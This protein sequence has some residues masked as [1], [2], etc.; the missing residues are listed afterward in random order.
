MRKKETPRMMSSFSLRSITVLYSSE[1][2][3]LSI[4]KPPPDARLISR[5]FVS[6]PF[7][8]LTGRGAQ[9]RTAERGGLKRYGSILSVKAMNCRRGF[10]P[11]RWKKFSAH[12]EVRPLR[13]EA[14]ERCAHREVR[15]EG[16]SV[17]TGMT[18][19]AAL[20]SPIGQQH[21]SEQHTAQVREVGDIV[22]VRYPRHKL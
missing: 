5:N 6:L 11:L 22:V 19:K 14:T 12:R 16:V 13:D 9:A 15:H 10:G 7:R 1:I 2:S 8:H 3:A 21:E 17:P 20:A 4:R 18:V